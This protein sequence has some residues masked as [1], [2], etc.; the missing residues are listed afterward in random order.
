M[1]L[2][3]STLY[4]RMRIASRPRSVSGETMSGEH[5]RNR[6]IANPAEDTL[7]AS[8]W[9]DKK[10]REEAKTKGEKTV[11]V[12]VC[13]ICTK[14]GGTLIKDMRQF[15]HRECLKASRR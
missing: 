2:S 10:N 1:I 14:I 9:L 7:K 12:L 3:G 8:Y 15:V 13:A 6:E 11:C 5:N 4:R